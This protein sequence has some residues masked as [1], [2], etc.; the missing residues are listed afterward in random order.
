MTEGPV[1]SA[2]EAA[3]RLWRPAAVALIGI[4]G[5]FEP[6]K[7]RL[8]DVI[9]PSKVFGYTEGKAAV[10]DGKERVTYRTTGHQLDCYLLA[11][12]RAVSINYGDAWQNESK[13][14]GLADPNL[15]PRL[16]EDSAGPKLHITNNDCLASGNTVVAS[17]CFA[18]G[19]R[20]AFGDAGS[21]IKA[22][23][24]EA[25]GTCEALAKAK[26]APPALIVRGISDLADEDKASLEKDFKDGWRRYAAQNAVRFLLAVIKH[27]PTVAE[28]FRHVAVPRY[29]MTAHPEST[30]LCLEARIAARNA[31]VR[32]V[33][34]RP[35]I[36]CDD[37]LPKT[38]LFLEARRRDGTPG[39]FSEI[40]LRQCDDERVLLRVR[41]EPRAET[42]LERTGE[43]RPLELLVGLPEDAVTIQMRAVDEFGRKTL[44]T[45]PPQGSA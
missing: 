14:A 8:G 7:V 43:P 11:E 18:E 10:V 45:W 30:R 44:A 21:T 17:R 27:R 4:A 42:T 32:T 34:F 16:Q 20:K 39:I 6:E 37:G 1:Q 23:E 35:F 9:I 2:V 25:K 40:L 3:V 22:V 33:A 31:G 12:A 19:V 13:E 36:V 41:G 38:Q 26:P 24:M 29:P 28:G 5:S 15:K